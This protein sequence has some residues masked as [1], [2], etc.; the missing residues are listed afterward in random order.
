MTLFRPLQEPLERPVRVGVLISGGG[1]TLLNFLEKKAAGVIDIEVPLVI[2]SR[3]DIKGISRAA[4]A[5]IPCEVICRKDFT[6]THS[7]SLAIFE[8]L[9][10]AKV[11]LVTLAGYLSLIEI[12][13][14]FHYR[15][16]NIHPAL[17]PAF[18]GKGFYGHHVHEAVVE[19]GVKVTGCTVHFADNAYDHGPIIVQRTVPVYS[20]DNADDVAARVFEAECDAYPEAIKLFV[21]AKLSIEDRRVHVVE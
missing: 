16:M 8:K 15:V 3:P 20:T 7:F 10:E 4:A 11:D 17:I 9:R 12:P 2:A 21:G 5:G 14:D 6:D 19:R 1:T 18:C 13:D